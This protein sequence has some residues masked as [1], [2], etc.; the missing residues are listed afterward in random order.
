MGNTDEV[1][2]WR[3]CWVLHDQFKHPD[4]E[5]RVGTHVI[6]QVNSLRYRG[7]FAPSPTGP[8]HL[9]SLVAAVASWIRARQLGGDWL[10]R[11]EDI[12]PPREV[13]GS[14]RGIVNTL[15]AFG[16][17]SDEP[18]WWQHQ[19][20]DAYTA[21]LDQLAAAGTVFPCWCS[22]AALGPEGIHHACIT[23]PDPSRDPAWRLRVGNGAVSF[24]DALQGTITDFPAV[25][26]G[27]IVVKR[28]DGLWAY[29]LAV[30]VDDAA[31][32]ITEVV[33]G[34]DLLDSTPRQILIQ[35]ALGLATPRYMHIPV[36]VDNDGVKLSKSANSIAV[37]S[38]DPI[39]ALRCALS[40]LGLPA[41][42]TVY[43]SATRLLACAVAELDLLTHA[44]RRTLPAPAGLPDDGTSATHGAG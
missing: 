3:L 28:S 2:F 37:D 14:A 42:A 36:L 10:L 35:Q 11:I 7:R 27:D 24:R 21:A 13:P 38:T 26:T 39:P 16:L 29:Q 5:K 17:V 41:R 43:G 4:I 1:A 34:A 18:V 15:A 20:G 22:R 6:Q 25:S 8:L 30:V 9:G 44:G 32:G 31:Q 33:R 40:L 19:R 23:D 12:D